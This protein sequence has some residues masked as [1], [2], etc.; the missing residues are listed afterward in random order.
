MPRKPAKRPSSAWTLLVYLAGDNNLTQEMTWSLQELKKT[1]YR[2]NP[3]TGPARVNVVAHF[4]PRGSRGRRYDFVPLADPSEPGPRADVDGNLDRY[5][6]MVYTDAMV[7]ARTHGASRGLP[8]PAHE[9]PSPA[10]QL[11]AFLRE[12]VSRLRPAKEYFLVLSGHGSGA[13]GD[14]LIDRD[15]GTSLSI[16]ELA[17]ILRDGR[18]YYAEAHGEYEDDG[19][20]GKRIGILGMD[21][22]LMSNAEV[23][24]EIREHARFLVGSEGFASNAGWPYHR[25]LEAMAGPG[26][27]RAIHV[28]QQ[29]AR[30]Y[31]N[32]Y[33][34]YEISGLS[35][36][37]AVCNLDVF[38]AKGKESLVERLRAFTREWVPR[39]EAVYVR[40]LLARAEFQ[41]AQ[42]RELLRELARA[43]AKDVAPRG[44]LRS[45]K[46]KLGQGRAGSL[47][48][49]DRVEERKWSVSQLRALR[50][51]LEVLE[52]R[53]RLDPRTIKTR[54][55]KLGL[56]W[57]K[58][59]RAPSSHEA[60]LAVARVFREFDPGVQDALRLIE[61][62]EAEGEP[63]ARARAR[64]QKLHEVRWLL[65]LHELTENLDE[66]GL[67]RPPADDRR[68]VDALVAAR[69][70]A[71]SFKGGVYVDLFDLCRCLESR[72]P[73]DGG[74]VAAA[75]AALREAIEGSRGRRNGA[76]VA[77]HYTGQAFQHAH[78]LSV[79]F[80][81]DAQAYALEYENLQL[82]QQ[83]G[84]GRFLRAYLRLTRQGRR[85]ESKHW[86]RAEDHVLRFGNTEV[87][88]LERDGLEARIVGVRTHPS[89]F[90]RFAFDEFR[91]GTEL[92]SRGG[93]EE[94]SRGGTEQKSR[95]ESGML[96]GWG[97]PPDGFFRRRAD[98]AA[99]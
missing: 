32:F 50:Q 19:V 24:F 3:R 6:A 40:D 66:P 38:C 56:R 37:I 97:N 28:A 26:S 34:D 12:Q 20:T 78:G 59:L 1:A 75:C 33:R 53:Y 92:K 87:D 99:R 46:T 61:E 62:R 36:D 94:K 52:A 58:E 10:H 39:L 89:T 22:C 31:W 88:P 93:T 2:V 47:R 63:A 43:I 15:P 27:G 13:V 29:V 7:E 79:Y 25:V 41:P 57:R 9:R 76:V 49:V 71:Q 91:G 72:L 64:L 35:T 18:K 30:N 98:D 70:Q 44:E 80:P 73:G 4:D 17:R 95:G 8:V 69:F 85:D 74:P 96:T 55:G 16:P 14:F 82:A 21:S 65:D 67:P 23:C 83:T 11:A 77:S 48:E 60:A 81:S 42:A 68:L 86:A 51:L 84:W 45:L 90:E 5:E 54:R